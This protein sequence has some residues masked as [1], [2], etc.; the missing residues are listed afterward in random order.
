MSLPLFDW[1]LSSL[2]AGASGWVEWL[3]GNWKGWGDPMSA[4][5]QQQ[6]CESHGGWW[7]WWIRHQS[8][9]IASKI[10]PSRCPHSQIRHP[11]TSYRQPKVGLTRRFLSPFCRDQVKQTNVA[12]KCCWSL[13]WFD[14]MRSCQNQWSCCGCRCMV[15]FNGTVSFWGGEEWK[16]RVHVMV[17]VTMTSI[18]SERY[19]W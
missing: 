7:E 3:P 14:F 16:I 10:C 15:W 18:C 8:Q 1:S 12:D 6:L 13:L 19:L 11:Q 9:S 17:A 5:A 2:Y 4:D